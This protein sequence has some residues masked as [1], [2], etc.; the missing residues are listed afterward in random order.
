MHFK[1][2]INQA[3]NLIRRYIHLIGF[4]VDQQSDDPVSS[5]DVINYTITTTFP[6]ASIRVSQSCLIR[7]VAC[8]LNL[9]TGRFTL[10]KLLD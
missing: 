9:I 1:I 6:F 4:R 3:L 7:R 10:F 5:A 2:F 8:A